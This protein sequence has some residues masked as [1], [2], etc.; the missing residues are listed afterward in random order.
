MVV[1]INQPSRPQQFQALQIANAGMGIAVN[2]QNFQKVREDREMA[3]AIRDEEAR[4]AQ[5][6]FE[7]TG[8][9]TE[10]ARAQTE[11]EQARGGLV[12][13][14]TRQTVEETRNAAAQAESKRKQKR[15]DSEQKL[16]N[17][18]R[19]DARNRQFFEAMDNAS[20][21]FSV[22]VGDPDK[23]NNLQVSAAQ[24]MIIRSIE[25][26]IINQADLLAYSP[27]ASAA[28]RMKRGF[29]LQAEGKPLEMDAKT[30]KDFAL[31]LQNKAADDLRQAAVTFANSPAGSQLGATDDVMNRVL[32]IEDFVKKAPPRPLGATAPAAPPPAAPP[33]GQPEAAGPGGT[34][35]A[36]PPP[37]S[38]FSE[39]EIKAVMDGSGSNRAQAIIRLKAAQ[40]AAGGTQ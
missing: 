35:L 34:P 30:F 19:K 17:E 10:R 28:A 27:D 36:P 12:R 4:Q 18:F 23:A 32:R 7:Q 15:T 24:R 22:L 1:A 2:Y 20:K 31:A 9:Q 37:P 26:G 6:V 5:A 8:V 33:P 21:A 11:T 40:Q 25:P 3:P 29:R 13:A 39:E 16:F 14:Q 38:E